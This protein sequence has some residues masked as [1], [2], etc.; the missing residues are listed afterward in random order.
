LKRNEKK[1]A[2]IFRFEA[3]KLVF[4]LL[5]LRSETPEIISETEAKKAQQ[6]RS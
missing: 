6:K 4:S 2:K 3:E 1:Q 5:S